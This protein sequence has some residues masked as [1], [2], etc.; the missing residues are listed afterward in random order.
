[1][2]SALK[3]AYTAGLRERQRVG[4]LRLGRHGKVPVST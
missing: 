2:V 4:A 1:M 3:L